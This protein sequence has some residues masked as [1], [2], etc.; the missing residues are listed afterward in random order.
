MV[1]LDVR[2]LRTSFKLRGTTLNAVN[3][4]SFSL[5]RGETLG[6]VGESGS[7]KTV[8]C[9]SIMGLLQKP[10][11]HI[12]GSAI[13]GTLDLVSCSDKEIRKVRGDRISMI[14]QDP[15][16]AFN[17]YLRICDQLIE[18]LLY[19]RKLSRKSAMNHALSMLDKTGIP[20]PSSRIRS[21]PHEFS[22]GMLQRAMIAMALV[23]HPEIL[24]ADEPTTAL[25]VTVQMQILQ[26]LKDLQKQLSMS[27]IFITHNLGIVAGF[28][29]RVLVMYA[30]RI[31]ESAPGDELFLNTAHP[32]TK[33]LIRSVPSLGESSTELLSIEG[34]PPDLT[35][36][37][38]G[39][40]FAQR[41]PCRA[42]ICT[43]GDME[44]Y[45]AGDSHF[46]SCIRFLKGEITL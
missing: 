16:A 39:C 37:I 28:C 35:K 42:E 19:H 44:L 40:P 30:G 41:C 27:V 43:E 21:Y 8:L 17:P 45:P 38:I 3:G 12:S 26:L 2:N 10:P 29:D 34:T 15:Q 31:L 11:A 1:L 6:I 5:T 33:A 9:H 18:P 36:E 25:D 24:I 13:F 4:V 23:T 7:G 20:D 32:Y 14:F 46:T 22:G